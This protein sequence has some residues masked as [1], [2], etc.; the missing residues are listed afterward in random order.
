MSGR[1]QIIP[2][3]DFSSFL[4]KRICILCRRRG[5]TLLWGRCISCCCVC[6]ILLH[7]IFMLLLCPHR[8]RGVNVRASWIVVIGHKNVF[9]S[10]QTGEERHFFCTVFLSFCNVS[11]ESGGGLAGSAFCSRQKIRDK[12]C[13][14]TAHVVSPLLSLDWTVAPS[15]IHLCDLCQN[16][17]KCFGVGN[18]VML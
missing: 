7:M 5:V 17:I 3:L 8:R 10:S 18:K 15:G 12:R 16:S 2:F 4:C 1:R 13:Q 6:K 9:V 14:T 11:Q